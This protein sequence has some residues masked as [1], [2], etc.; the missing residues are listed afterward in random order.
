MNINYTEILIIKLCAVPRSLEFLTAHLHG[1]DPISI[2]DFL[3]DMEKK[4][5]L[6]H[7]DDLWL[8]E[9]NARKHV[10]DLL[11]PN[12][13][14]YL[15]KYMGEFAT[16]TKPH[17]R[18]FEWRNTK[19]SVNYLSE[20]ALNGSAIEDH[21]LIL[22]MPTLFANLCKKD[23]PQR[24]TIV[25]RNKGVIENLKELSHERCKVIEADIFKIDPE[26]LGRYS[27]IVMDPPWY[28]EQ[29]LQFMWVA[30]Q[31]LNLAGRLIISI[32]PINTRPGIGAERVRWFD[33]SERQGLCLYDLQA[34]KLEYAMPFFEW[35]A[36]R[37][38][39]AVVSPFWRHG[40]VAIFHKLESKSGFRPEHHEEE[41]LWHEV[42]IN[43][44]RFR[45][46]IDNKE[47]DSSHEKIEI[48]PLATSPTNILES[49]S[50]R[51][52]IRQEA[53]IWTSG[54]RIYRTNKPM[55]VYSSLRNY[56]EGIKSNSE[57]EIEI[58]NFISLISG[59]ENDEHNEYLEWLYKYMESEVT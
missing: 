18:D 36:A 35:N 33:F 42:E 58:F 30:S 57:E 29:F 48:K 22:G 26:T 25:E 37:A 24:V 59:F 46:K 45:V 47:E 54:N 23:I 4:E 15:K 38:A 53:N 52:P 32:P 12:P 10:T 7:Q 49:V 56:E 1:I 55:T 16:F 13:E 5:L 51:K 14:L 9:E 8:I 11:N 43:G 34:N 3:N 27:T 2:L 17:P 39:G 44:C 6:R 40:D 28:E 41:N 31:C 19:K 21:I 50:T 20:L